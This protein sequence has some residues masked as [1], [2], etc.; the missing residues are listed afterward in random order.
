[1]INIVTS[2]LTK[3]PCYNSKRMIKV[4][5]LTLHSIG[6]PQPNAQVF[7]KN[8]NSSSYNRACVHGFI[9][10]T[11]CYITL[12]CMEETHTGDVLNG[13]VRICVDF[14]HWQCEGL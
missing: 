3:N 7:I 1:M 10:N 4:Q 9:D 8:W 6:C 13:D 12:P 2:Y 14:V 11:G 5:G